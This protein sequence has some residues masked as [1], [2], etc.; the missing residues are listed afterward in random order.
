MKRIFFCLSLVILT[1][2]YAAGQK[3]FVYGSN[4]E[5]GQYVHVN[6]ISLY[7]EIYGSGHP[8]LI[9]HGNG[10]SIYDLRNQIKEFAKYYKVVAVDSRAQGLST[11]SD[12]ELSFSLMA[13]DMDQLLDS[14]KIDSAYVL[15][16]SDGAIIGLELALKYPAKV[17]KL[18]ADGA[19]FV[20][21]STALPADMIRDMKNTT[22]AKL[23]SASQR[24]IIMHSHF[25]QR[26]GI[27][28][29]KLNRLDLYHPNFTI[30]Q[31]NSIETPTLVMAG[32]HD[33]IIDTHTL[34]L[35]HSL[36]NA[37]LCII[38][39][40]SH[41]LLLE[42]PALANEIILKFLQRPFKEIR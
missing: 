31:L 10:G 22:F 41:G 21:D 19:N 13:S 34:K 36:P 2:V 4:A 12:Q 16:W 38:P 24:N 15:G 32:D 29:D 23:D 17:A 18:I 35:F 1:A 3:K 11:D 25:P 30:E 8:L 28:Y 20:P 7:Y 39:G 40:A 26:A 37:E 5:A 27:I 9:M 42:R 33:I 6:G 14:L